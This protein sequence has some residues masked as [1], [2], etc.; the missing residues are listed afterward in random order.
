MM[1]LWNLKEKVE[2]SIFEVKF[3][4]S[5]IKCVPFFSEKKR[6]ENKK[7]VW[8]SELAKQAKILGRILSRNVSGFFLDA[9]EQVKPD[10]GQRRQREKR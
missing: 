2:S 7:N 9:Q 4:N 1:I 8:I 3:A 6:F 10:E 5:R